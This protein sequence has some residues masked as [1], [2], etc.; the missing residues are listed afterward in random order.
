MTPTEFKEQNVIF[1]KDQPE[2]NPLPAFLKPEDA[3]GTVITKWELSDEEIDFI[4]KTKCVWL[5]V[6]TFNN[7]L[8]PQLL[9]VEKPEE[10]N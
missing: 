9:Q 1:S 6:L 5:T 4:K 3:E 2:Y 7:P 8:Q 10:L